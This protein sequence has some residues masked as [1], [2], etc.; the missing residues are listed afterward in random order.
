[1]TTSNGKATAST[2]TMVPMTLEEI[3]E[4]MGKGRIKGVYEAK[5]PIFIESD[6]PAIDVA[7]TWPLEFGKK[8]ASTLYQGFNNLVNKLD[9]KDTIMVKRD[10]E[11]VVLVHLGRVQAMREALSA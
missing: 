7:E 5:L 2:K 4:L 1:M 8:Q 10:G 9:L 11:R 6:D 3:E